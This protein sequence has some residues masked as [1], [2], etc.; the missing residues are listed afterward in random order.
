MWKYIVRRFAYMVFTVWVISIISFVVIQLPPGDFVTDLVSQ[1]IAGGAREI[2]PE[3]EEA[4]RELYGLNQPMYMQ[5]FKWMRN[6]LLKWDF[7][8]SYIY[9]KNTVELVGER[10]PLTLAVSISSVL[11]IWIVALP[12]GIYSAVKQYSISDYTFT[13]LGFI[14]LATPNFLLALI[15]MFIS[16]K[17]FG[18]AMIGLFSQKFA[19]APWSFAKFLDLLKHLWIPVIIVG[20][21]GTAGLIRTM[22]ANLLDELNKPYVETARAKGLSEMKLLWKYPVRHALNPFVSTIGLTLPG[23]I[24]GAALTAIVLNLPTA[25]PILLGSLM[26]Q[27]M[28]VAAS[29]ILLLSALTVIGIFISDLLLAWLDPRIRLE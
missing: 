14:G 8:Y 21:S 13:F 27:D 20:T 22:R 18:Q 9:K 7:G 12:I 5:Y 25:G 19:E 10:L 11:F 24:S 26:S 2:P 3:Y 6:I 16:Y 15:F 28:Y 17:Y 29:F 1:M 23:L 4:M